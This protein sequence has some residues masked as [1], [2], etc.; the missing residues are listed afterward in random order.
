MQCEGIPVRGLSLV[1]FIVEGKAPRCQYKMLSWGYPPV[2]FFVT[3]FALHA[4]KNC[5]RQ[6]G[7]ASRYAEKGVDPHLQPHVSGICGPMLQKCRKK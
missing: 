7:A 1:V 4:A 5:N 2:T 3:D 6:A